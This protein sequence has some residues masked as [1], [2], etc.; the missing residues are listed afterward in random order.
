MVEKKD[1]VEP[2]TV[3]CEICMKEIPKSVAHSAEGAEYVYHFCGADCFTKWQAEH[4]RG[5]REKKPR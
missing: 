4:E 3:A 2:E 1:I 5:E